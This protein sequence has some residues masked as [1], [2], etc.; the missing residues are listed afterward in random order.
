MGT[1]RQWLGVLRLKWF[2]P[3]PP[4]FVFTA[5]GR[6]G[7]KY[8]AILLSRLG[9]PCGHENDFHPKY[10]RRYG[11]I[12]DASWLAVP[13]LPTYTGTVLH[14]L[15]GPLLII[16]SLVGIRL[17]SN[18][19]PREPYH[20]FIHQHFHAN[21][22]DVLNTMRWYLNWNQRI[23]R[24]APLRYRVEDVSCH[25][26]RR[27]LTILHYKV[28]DS[29]STQA[30]ISS[31]S[32]STKMPKHTPLSWKDLAETS[33]KSPLRTLATRYGYL[34]SEGYILTSPPQSSPARNLE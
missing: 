10:P 19:R 6:C 27:I 11:M 25:L 31:P 34:S 13:P 18:P 22:D 26:I 15:T 16:S 24:C 9:V 28:P 7:T 17:F 5:I 12:R 30:E 8:I 4:D 1:I 2:P 21:G 14:Q 3:R 20:H 32:T 29:A 33:T 23:E